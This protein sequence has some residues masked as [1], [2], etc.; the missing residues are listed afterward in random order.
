MENNDYQRL[1]EKLKR[2][3]A[4]YA[5]RAATVGE[6]AAADEAC[7]RIRQRLAE[8]VQ[9]D[10]PVEYNFALRNPW[11]HSLFVALLRRY[12]I[13][14]YRYARQRYTTVMARVPARFVRETLWPEFVE[15]NR[16]LQSYLTEETN[17][18]IAESIHNDNSDVEVR[19]GQALPATSTMETIES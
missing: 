4:L 8:F 16:T 14:P 3:E 6:K 12:N 17:R 9:V 7:E 10:P 5:D 2:I 18:V 1:I 13:R 19:S 11:S 15:L